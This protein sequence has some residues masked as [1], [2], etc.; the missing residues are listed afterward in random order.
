MAF[1]VAWSV[2][3]GAYARSS[4]ENA[5]TFFLFIMM[6]SMFL[7]ALLYVLNPPITS[8]LE[9][10]VINMIVMTVGI[11]LVLRYWV[12]RDVEDE[13]V[14]ELTNEDLE[15]SVIITRAYVIYFVVFVASMSVFAILYVVNNTTI[16]TEIAL[17]SGMGIMTVGV[18]LILRY[19]MQHRFAP[20]ESST[21]TRLCKSTALR[22]AV[23]FLFLLNEFLMGWVFASA[24]GIGG[25]TMKTDALTLFGNVVSS[26]WFIFI[27]V[28]EMTL[29]I[30]MFRKEYPSKFTTILALQAAV[31]LFSAPAIKNDTWNTMSI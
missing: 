22:T 1:A 31:M 16:G 13:K 7:G 27:M 9:A 23:I 14:E 6:A 3:R 24:S 28:V 5:S 4:V 20:Y 8:I 26:Y 10:V 15:R 19:S 2:R 29:T 30:V 11:L 12:E 17:A 18:L 21:L 25:T